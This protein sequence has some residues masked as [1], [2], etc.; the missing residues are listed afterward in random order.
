VREPPKRLITV[1]NQAYKTG[2]DLFQGERVAR[3]VELEAGPKRVQ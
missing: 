2:D 1:K 3:V